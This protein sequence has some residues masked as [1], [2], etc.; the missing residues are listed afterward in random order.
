[1]FRWV[2]HQFRGCSR[3]YL[4]LLHYHQVLAVKVHRRFMR[5]E[6]PPET[7]IVDQRWPHNVAVLPAVPVEANF[8]VIEGFFLQSRQKKKRLNNMEERSHER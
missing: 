1:M 4:G 7:W 2:N 3:S 8:A 6:M 5:M